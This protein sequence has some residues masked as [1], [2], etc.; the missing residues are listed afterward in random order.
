[1]TRYMLM[2]GYLTNTSISSPEFY[3]FKEFPHT[4]LDQLLSTLHSISK[5]ELDFADFYLDFDDINEKYRNLVEEFIKINFQSSKIRLFSFR[6]EYFQQWEK[7]ANMIPVSAATVLLMNNLDH[8]FIPSSKSKFLEFVEFL[9]SSKANS[10]GGILHWQ[11]SIHGL[12][13]KKLKNHN[14]SFPI[15]WNQTYWTHGV[16]LIKS[17]F[18][19]SWWDKDFTEGKRIV[20]PDNPFGPYVNFD[21]TTRYV[22]SIEFFRHLDGYGHVGITSNRAASLRPCCQYKNGEII[23]KDWKVGFNKN[24]LADLPFERPNKLN[25][26]TM[27]IRLNPEITDYLINANSMLFSF[28]RSIQIIEPKSAIDFF[29]L[30]LNLLFLLKHSF[31]REA[32]YRNFW[33]SKLHK[34][35]FQHFVVIKYS[36][37]QKKHVKLPKHMKDLKKINLSQIFK[38]IK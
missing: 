16:T 24:D 26:A 10:I 6:L 30:L 31:L 9:E 2:S 11:E 36:N 13:T 35:R 23:H 21:W 14:V 18:F 4:K 22:P 1:M 12:G 8:V 15:F 29:K 19:K 32:L 7:A 34:Y 20:R 17:S 3:N 33:P 37:F 27:Q 25:L 28:K 38:L 5:L